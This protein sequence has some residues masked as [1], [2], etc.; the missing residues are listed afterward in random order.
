[1]SDKKVEYRTSTPVPN[2]HRNRKPPRLRIER[3][4][5]V[6][7]PVMGFMGFVWGLIRKTPVTIRQTKQN[8][9]SRKPF[10]ISRKGNVW[11]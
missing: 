10:E 11:K 4:G 8:K 9:K 5:T 2:P 1:M 7:D 6:T 3:S